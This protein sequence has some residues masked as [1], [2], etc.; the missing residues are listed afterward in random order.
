MTDENQE[1]ENNNDQTEIK[2]AEKKL[3]DELKQAKAALKQFEKIKHVDVA[4]YEALR[5]ERAKREEDDQ[6]AKGKYDELVAQKTESFNK[7]LQAKAD[8]LAKRDQKLISASVSSAISAEEGIPKLLSHLV[9]PR[10]KVNDDGDLVVVDENG[11]VEEG[12]SV[13]DLVKELKK[14]GDLAVAFKSSAATGTGSTS[15]KV[16]TTN[17]TQGNPWMSN[18]WNMTTQ[19]L[20]E[21]TNPNLAAQMKAAAGRK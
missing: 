9:L 16:T 7:D 18:T 15:Q 21:K 12:K 19:A 1:I 17:A 10:V 14:D 5:A 4:E 8:L 6:L 20:L 2:P 11:V 3:L 13:Q